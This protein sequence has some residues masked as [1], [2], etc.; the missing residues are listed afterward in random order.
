MSGSTGNHKSRFPV[1]FFL[2]VFVTGYS[3]R[4]AL[5]CCGNLLIIS[6]MARILLV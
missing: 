5:K 6:K 4:L 1:I 2:K 3:K